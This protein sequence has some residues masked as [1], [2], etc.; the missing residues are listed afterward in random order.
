MLLKI[1]L[2]R[3]SKHGEILYDLSQKASQDTTFE[4]GCKSWANTGD[5][6]TDF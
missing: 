6:E 1:K 5:R 3:A 2:L 4:L